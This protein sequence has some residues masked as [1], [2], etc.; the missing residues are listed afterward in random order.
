M[1]KEKLLELDGVSE[2]TLKEFQDA[3]GDDEDEGI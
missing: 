3:K 1:D 2:E